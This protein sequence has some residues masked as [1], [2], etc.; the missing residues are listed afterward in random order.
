MFPNFFPLSNSI[1]SPNW[2]N[3]RG[4]TNIAFDKFQYKFNSSGRT[5]V[6]DQCCVHWSLHKEDNA[7]LMVDYSDDQQEQAFKAMLAGFGNMKTSPS[8]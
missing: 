2:K 7:A 4:E 8:S 3:N 5:V 6:S 1:F